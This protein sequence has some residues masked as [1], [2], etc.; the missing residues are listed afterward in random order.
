MRC[1]DIK[2]KMSQFLLFLIVT[3]ILSSCCLNRLEIQTQYFTNEDLA[4]FYVE[5]PDPQLHCSIQGERLLIQ[6]SLRKE[7][8]RNR[9]LFLNLKVRFRTREEQNVSVRICKRSGTYVYEL[10][11]ETYCQTQ[12]ILTYDVEITDGENIVAAWKHPLWVDLIHL[13]S[14]QNQK[15]ESSADDE[16]LKRLRAK[17]ELENFKEVK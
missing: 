8:L 6:W 17:I 7:E 13:D 15:S 11:G 2:L 12:G 16:E 9:E 3:I 1:H 14:K 4:S 10:K 5:T